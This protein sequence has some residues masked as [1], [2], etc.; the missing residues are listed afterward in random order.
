M[1]KPQNEKDIQNDNEKEPD[2]K[3]TLISVSLLAAFLIVA[4][5]GVWSLYLS[6]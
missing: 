2:L 1:S 5:F 6:R 3:G 4:W